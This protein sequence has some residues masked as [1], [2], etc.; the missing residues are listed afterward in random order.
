MPLRS[1]CSAL[2][3]I[4]I[5]IAPVEADLTNQLMMQAQVIGARVGYADDHAEAI[6]L[7]RSDKIDL[8][9]FITS[10]ILAEDVVRDG[11]EKLNT[12]KDE[13]KILVSM[14]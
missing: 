13:V 3:V 4:A 9:P 10:K 6:E 2:Q 12:S 14:G 8:G 5:H 1:P 7:V 11:L